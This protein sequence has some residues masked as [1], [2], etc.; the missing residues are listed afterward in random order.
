MA[1]GRLSLNR[2]SPS[3]RLR[4]ERRQDAR[5]GTPRAAAG[6][7]SRQMPTTLH[8]TLFRPWTALCSTLG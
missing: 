8:M 6:L 5:Q 7:A 1:P 2:L 3:F 4:A